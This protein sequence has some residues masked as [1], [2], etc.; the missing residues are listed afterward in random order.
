MKRNLLIGIVSAAGLASGALAQTAQWGVELVLDNDPRLAA[1]G[2]NYG[3]H[4]LL[5]GPT[6]TAVGITL[7]ARVGVTGGASSL[8]NFGVAAFGGGGNTANPNSRFSHN[9]AISNVT[10]TLWTSPALAMQRGVSDPT[11][12]MRGLISSTTMSGSPDG[13]VANYRGFL[14]SGANYNGA[15]GNAATATTPNDSPYTSGVNTANGFITLSGGSAVILAATGQRGALSTSGGSAPTNFGTSGAMSPWY[16]L[17]HMVFVPRTQGHD[18]QDAVRDVTVSFEGAFRYATMVNS[19]GGNYNFA[20]SA[21]SARQT[22][23]VTFTVPTPGAMAVLGLG[24]L[25]AGRRR[26]V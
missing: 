4:A 12:A 15:T 13:R 21:L 1:M 18:A 20:T 14:G 22:A 17:Y 8:G 25:V 9:D 23:S 24:G 26:R 5:P 11:G 6:A 2:V 16:A 19:I 3:S 7:I 10:N